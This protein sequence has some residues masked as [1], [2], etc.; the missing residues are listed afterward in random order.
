MAGSYHRTSCL[1]DPEQLEAL[2]K[3][4]IGEDL[5]PVAQP[6]LWKTNDLEK[7]VKNYQ[8]FLAT[9]AQRGML[10]DQSV[11]V[12][13]LKKQFEGDATLLKAFAEAMGKCLAHCK[14][15]SASISHGAK[16]DAAV[17]R[18]ARAWAKNQ[19][20][21]NSSQDLTD[22][23]LTDGDSQSSELSQVSIEVMTVSTQAASAEELEAQKAL[24]QAKAAFQS[25]SSSS[26]VLKRNASALSVAS[27]K[28][29]PTAASAA[30]N[31]A[32]KTAEPPKVLDI[33]AFHA[34]VPDDMRD[35][36]ITK[37]QYESLA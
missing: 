23:Q 25:S 1:K 2:V 24:T 7:V 36:L 5:D 30:S 3:L 10:L 32:T 17:L 16:T 20:G 15:K 35:T 21:K 29:E 27:S 6:K 9:M 28:G 22:T 37:S 12:K 8:E 4:T 34:C 31:P 26:R 33:L 11:F 18:V 13:L 14:K 19:P